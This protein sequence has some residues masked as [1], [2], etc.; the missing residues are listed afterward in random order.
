MN[1][2]DSLGILTLSFLGAG[3]RKMFVGGTL[4][5]KLI[6]GQSDRTKKTI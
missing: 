1:S 2:K 5:D 6:S 4:L 3:C